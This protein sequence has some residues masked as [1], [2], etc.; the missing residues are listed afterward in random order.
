MGKNKVKLCMTAGMFMLTFILVG[1]L[2]LLYSSRNVNRRKERQKKI[3]AVYMTMNN[4]YFEVIN[5]KIKAVARSRGDV[6]VARDSAMDAEMQ[7]R[8]IKKLIEEKVDL[9][10]VN[11][12]DW[13]KISEGL[14]AA[15]EAGIPV[16]AL[17]AEVYDD[18]LVAGTVVSD[19]YTAGVLCARDLM[20]K[21]DGGKILFLIQKTNK[22]AVERIRGFKETLDKAGWKYEV[23]DELDCQGQ[24]EV[25][26][27][28]VEQVLQKRQD[29][30]VVMGLNDPSSL[31]AMA[32]LDAE[33]MLS[34]VLVYSV[35]GAPESKTMIYE[36][37]MTATAA[38]SP[39]EVGKVTA[40]LLYRLLDGEA[41]PEKTVI[42]VELI[43]EK[44]IEHYSLSE[45]E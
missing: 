41:I 13:K 16:I 43:T 25:A 28:M 8:Q 38:Q 31:G 27:P 1:C 22:S 24:L 39:T 32:A 42:P 33:N 19:N 26:Q 5:E 17:D 36:G 11:A 45:W 35:D 4:P 34:Q 20:K 44:N 7:N 23:V 40:R 21:R 14:E 3:G 6:M 12:V 30:D 37:R 2:A 9:L 15:G 10:L 18:S 29:I